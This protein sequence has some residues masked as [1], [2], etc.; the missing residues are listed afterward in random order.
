M[1]VGKRAS[2]YGDIHSIRTA[3]SAFESLDIRGRDEDLTPPRY[4]REWA[5]IFQSSR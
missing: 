3:R 2:S 5:S 4:E 1:A